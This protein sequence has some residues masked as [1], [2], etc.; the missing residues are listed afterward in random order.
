MGMNSV[1]ASIIPITEDEL[2]TWL[3]KISGNNAVAGAGIA[4]LSAQITNLEHGC[5]S[6]HGRSAIPAC[7]QFD[8]NRVPHQSAKGGIWKQPLHKIARYISCILKPQ[9][10]A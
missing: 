9:K 6:L 10:T 1:Q 5:T 8:S 7:E 4:F 3:L 2:A